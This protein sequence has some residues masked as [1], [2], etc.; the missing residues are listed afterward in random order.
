MVNFYVKLMP[1]LKSALC[2]VHPDRSWSGRTKILENYNRILERFEGDFVQSQSDMLYLFNDQSDLKAQSESTAQ[3]MTSWRESESVVSI[4]AMMASVLSVFGFSEKDHEQIKCIL[5]AGVLAEVPNSL[6][7]HNVMHFRKVVFHMI[8]MIIAHNY[9]F[10]GGQNVLKVGDVTQLL[11]AA[12]IHDLG[13]DGGGNIVDRVYYMGRIEKRSFNLALPYLKAC[14]LSEEFLEN[15]RIMLIG[16]DASPFGDPFSPVCQIRAAYEYH[17]GSDEE[18]ASLLLREDLSI[19]RERSDL[20]LFCMMLHEADVMNSAGVS[21]EVTQKES[22]AIAREIG[23]EASPEDTLLFLEKICHNEMQTHS[24]QYLAQ[25]NFE[26][27]RMRIM[28]DYRNGNVPY[29]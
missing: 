11:I 24:A 25:D 23:T 16:T 29:G 14:G 1:E 13:H 18:E 21:Y 2:D 27:I 17:Y 5:M 7:Y 12:C 10:S 9:I 26:S 6:P 3:L 19:L 15:I 8:R 4:P 22:V 28:D 20:T